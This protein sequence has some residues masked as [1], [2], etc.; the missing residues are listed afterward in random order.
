MCYLVSSLADW[1]TEVIPRLA[2]RL[3]K[4]GQEADICKAGI[5]LLQ[6][7][8][9]PGV[10]QG[11]STRGSVL[12]CL[13]SIHLELPEPCKEINCWHAECEP[14]PKTERLR[15]RGDVGQV[16]PCGSPRAL[17]DRSP[18]CPGWLF[19]HCTCTWL[20]PTAS[21][22]HRP[23]SDMN[24]FLQAQ[25]VEALRVFPL[26]PAACSKPAYI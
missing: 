20:L 17:L 8:H 13:T 2:R 26:L 19:G 11:S 4:S 23:A 3:S 14:G 5:R 18:A 16:Q 15:H 10:T 22:K 24:I 1:Q 21:S 25:H 6:M 7:L 9:S 12:R